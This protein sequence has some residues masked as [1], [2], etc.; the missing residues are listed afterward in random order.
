VSTE[1]LLALWYRALHSPLGVEIITSDPEKVKAKL[2]RERADA[3]D[4]ELDQIS[5]SESPFDPVKLW[6]VKRARPR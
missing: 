5:I 6:L 1:P 4:L 3:K 2:Y